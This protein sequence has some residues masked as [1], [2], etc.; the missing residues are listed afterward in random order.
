MPLCVSWESLLKGGLLPFL[1][2]TALPNPPRPGGIALVPK[3]FLP[4]EERTLA[5]LQPT[6]PALLQPR[7]C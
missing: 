7:G 2:E 5:Q 1:K 6:Q 3:T 4:Q